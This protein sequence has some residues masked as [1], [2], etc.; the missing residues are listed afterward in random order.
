MLAV[1]TRRSR[2][3]PLSGAGRLTTADFSVWAPLLCSQCCLHLRSSSAVMATAVWHGCS[4]LR[5]WQ[6][7]PRVWPPRRMLIEEHY[8]WFL[9]TYDSLDE[10][11]MR[12]D[13]VRTESCNRARAVRMQPAQPWPRV[14]RR[15]DYCSWPGDVEGVWLVMSM[16]G[17]LSAVAN[18]GCVSNHRRGA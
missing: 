13:A 1:H 3:F 16:G 14:S 10:P 2:P 6:P 18:P 9:E 7:K 4:V 5:H 15:Y 12:A 17:S 11:I 8:P